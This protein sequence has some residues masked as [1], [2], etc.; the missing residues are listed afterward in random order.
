M[1]GPARGVTVSSCV[2]GC[3]LRFQLHEIAD[4]TFS[5]FLR[6]L[7]ER[8]ERMARGWHGRERRRTKMALST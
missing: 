1:H 6:G 3:P 4:G 8:R 2:N 5:Q 7:D